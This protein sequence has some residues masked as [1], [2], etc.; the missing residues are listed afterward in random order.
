MHVSINFLSF[1]VQADKS[2]RWSAKQILIIVISKDM[3]NI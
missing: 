2:T 1:V 3:K